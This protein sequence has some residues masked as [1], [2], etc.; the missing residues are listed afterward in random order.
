MLGTDL[1]GDALDMALRAGGYVDDPEDE[2]AVRFEKPGD[3]AK[4][5]WPGTVQ[6]P[7]LDLIDEELISALETPDARVAITMPP[8]EGKSTRVTIT[9]PLFYL[10]RNPDW[11]IVIASYQQDLANE[12]GY[13]IRSAIQD[14]QGEDG[15]LDLG[16][17][18]RPDHGAVR[19]WKLLGYNGGIRVAGVGGGVTG[20]PADA[21]FIDDPISNMEQAESKRYR[22]RVWNFWTAV[23]STRLAPGAPVFVVLTRW[24]HD[25]LIGRLKAGEDGH[26][27][28][29]I[30]IPAQADHDPDKGEEDPLGREP[31]VYLQSARK[32]TP[33]DWDAIKIRVGPRVWNAL[34]QGRP[35]AVRGGIFTSDWEEYDEPFWMERKDGSK[36]IPGLAW[37]EWEVAQSWDMAFKDLDSSDYVVG[38]VWVRKGVR[39]FLVH[40]VR[41]RMNFTETCEAVEEVTALW[42]QAVQKFVEDKA[43]GTA[44]INALQKRIPG[45]I[46]IEPEGSKFA[47]A[48]A[49]S[50]LS[51]SGNIVLPAPLGSDGLPFAPWIVDFKEECR[52]FPNG[53]NDDQVDA[54]SQAVNRILLMPLM[55]ESVVEPEE[56]TE[57]DARGWSISPV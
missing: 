48:S 52:D 2:T 45:F 10:M 5:L 57:H 53:A 9:G 30:N 54:M 3:L 55:E 29:V 1:W 8:Q 15:T 43:N 31:G 28:K 6:T 36:F 34:Y 51:H 41:R 4:A 21:L 56:F 50:P 24:H 17:R 20:R 40:Q 11:R 26:L 18:I 44:V 42:P 22:D 14:N 47:R 35:T 16:L 33:K 27:W 49:I 38:Q 7:A 23:G 12:F 39:A 19:N 46:P 13:A 25:D 32:R 37:P